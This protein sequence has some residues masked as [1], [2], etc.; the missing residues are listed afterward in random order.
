MVYFHLSGI[1]EFFLRRIRPH[2]SILC[3]E[4]ASYVPQLLYPRRVHGFD[5]A[6][7]FVG[8]PALVQPLLLKQVKLLLH[9]IELLAALQLIQLLLAL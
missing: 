2:T 1:K 8:L 5:V 4:S 3:P 9:L 7:C 6:Y